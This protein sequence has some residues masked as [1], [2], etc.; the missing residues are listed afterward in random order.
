ML[1]KL[2]TLSLAAVAL[3]AGAVSAGAQETKKDKEQIRIQEDVIVRQGIETFNV[4][5]DQ[6]RTDVQPAGRADNTFV[7][8]SSEM[9]LG[10][11]VVKGAP[12]S[13]EAV[14]ESVQTFADGNRIVRKN[15]AQVYRDSEGRT[16]REQTLN[17]LG[18]YAPDGEPPTTILIN[19]P[20]TG[21]NYAL[22][23]RH[24]TARKLA[25]A[26]FDN[27]TLGADEAKRLAESDAK[28]VLE[29]GFVYTT[30]VPPPPPPPPPPGAGGGSVYFYA[31]KADDKNT[32]TESLGTQV[33]EGVQAEGSRT[34]TTIPAG[35]IGNEQPIEIVR[36]RWYSPELQVVV[37]TVS[38]DPRMGTTTYRLTN[39]QRAEPAPALFQVPS[40]YTVVEAPA[41]RVR[42]FTR[43]P[44]AGGGG[45]QFQFQYQ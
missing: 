39:L 45:H 36:E 10:G 30:P 22:D 20:V 17:V 31:G 21:V 28:R 34:V 6:L 32:K 4:K 2:S 7:F 19:D 12:Y 14:T 8:V 44:G 41:P 27:R 43:K 26:R 24:R 13:A 11:K 5:V 37:K 29:Q 38:S 18:P 42:T 35:Q 16:R 1:K 23:P 9:S 40:D 15:T 25:V 33:V 3:V